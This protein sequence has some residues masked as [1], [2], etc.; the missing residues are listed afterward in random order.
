MLHA[1]TG[2]VPLVLEAILS[3]TPRLGVINPEARR[4]TVA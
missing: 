3:A 4:E 1:E 2:T